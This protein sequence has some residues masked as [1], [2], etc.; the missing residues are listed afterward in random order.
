MRPDAGTLGT[1]VCTVLFV[2]AARAPAGE[3]DLRGHRGAVQGL[4]FAPD[5]R[6]LASGGAD[7]QLRVWD[8]THG[9]AIA[10]RN[11][12]TGGVYCVAVSPT[13]KSIA[14][15]GKDDT[16]RV[17]SMA[18]FAPSRAY[19]L[20]KQGETMVPGMLG[21][22]KKPGVLSVGF[23]ADGRF[24][25]SGHADYRAGVWDLGSGKVY[26]LQGSIIDRAS[27][28]APQ[29]AVTAVAV[30]PNRML[31]AAG[32]AAATA[33]GG[34]RVFIW[35]PE[36]KSL[37][38]AL[39]EKSSILF[40]AFLPD[41]TRVVAGT[42]AGGVFMWNVHTGELVKSM[43]HGGAAIAYAA[44]RDG[45]RLVSAGVNSILVTD[46]ATGAQH[47][48]KAPAGALITAL[49]V[50]DDGTRIAIG[51]RD[52]VIRIRGAGKSEDLF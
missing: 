51:C 13:S 47:K 14:T 45:K 19:V 16:V 29:R 31:A 28:K 25:M 50:S 10:S 43:G 30:A 7:G 9:V 27:F 11:A 8:M 26:I 20:P 34:S 46:L 36:E 39:E 18:T 12:H 49:A 44:T 15:G 21:A 22:G 4:S 42:A 17:W 5:G 3:M 41:N 6:R 23:S 35:R 33:K 52:G 24:V 32:E 2:M 37:L 1:V 38:R 40:L 48:V